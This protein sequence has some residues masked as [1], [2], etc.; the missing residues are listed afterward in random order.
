MTKYALVLISILGG[1]AVLGLIIAVNREDS[2]LSSASTVE[3][4]GETPNGRETG[5]SDKSPLPPPRQAAAPMPLTQAMKSSFALSIG[6]FTASIDNADARLYDSLARLTFDSLT[7][8]ERLSKEEIEWGVT[9]TEF[10]GVEKTVDPDEWRSVMSDLRNRGFRLKSID[11]DR[12]N[13]VLVFQQGHT[14]MARMPIAIHGSHLSGDSWSLSGTVQIEWK[15]VDEGRSASITSIDARNLRFERRARFRGA[16][17]PEPPLPDHLKAEVNEK[18]AKLH[19]DQIEMDKTVWAQEVEAQRYEDT[20][21]K[22]WDRMLRPSDDKYAVLASIPF[23]WI[24]FGSPVDSVLLDWGI[25]RTIFGG[26]VTRRDRAAWKTFLNEM[27]NKSY[28]I[29]NIEFH[30]SS[31]EKDDAG[32]ARS[33]YSTELHVANQDRS[34][35]W[36]VTANLNIEWSDQTDEAD[37]YLIR[38]IKVVDLEVLE[39]EGPPDT[40]K[41]RVRYEG[42]LPV[43]FP[44]LYD[45]DRDGRSEVLLP[46]NNVVL[47]N[48]FTEQAQETRLFDAP[49]ANP[50]VDIKAAVIADFTKDGYADILCAGYDESADHLRTDENYYALLLFRG[51]KDGRFTQP[52]QPVHDVPLRI[53]DPYCMTA[54]DVDGDGD[55]DVWVGQYMAPYLRGQLPTPFHDANDGNPSYLLLNESNGRFVDVTESAGL[56]VKRHRRNYSGSLVDL[57]GDNDLDLLTV[58]D[59]AGIDVYHNDGNGHFSD[60]TN[61]VVDDASNF[62]MA[63]SVADYTLDGK[64][65]FYVIGMSSTTVRRLDQMGIA[66]GDFP[67]YTEM[68]TRMGYGNRMYLGESGGNFKEPSFRDRVARSG[69]AW[70]VTSFDFDSDG[71]LDIYIANGHISRETT[72]DYCSRFWC[73]DVYTNASQEDFARAGFFLDTMFASVNVMSWDGYQKNHLFMNQAGKDFTNVGFLLDVAF[74][75][76]SRSVASDDF[77]LD[78]RPDLLFTNVVQGKR[79]RLLRVLR[80]NWPVANNWIG[81]RLQ[82]EPGA[83][84]PIGAQIEIK[85]PSGKQVARIVTGDSFR[86]QHAPMKHFGLGGAETV[87][88]VRVTWPD[89]R[90]HTERSPAIN[91]YHLVRAPTS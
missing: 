29:I 4:S 7:I 21:V 73:H 3:L 22:Y 54:G 91:T 11:F 71:D 42:R 89:G 46:S 1:L 79:S 55:L 50:P 84:S 63:H 24:S 65:D 16:S 5:S 43:T 80:N 76:D 69:W 70:G 66:R 67:E 68:R 23:D 58:N 8:G 45:L 12:K 9:A 37:R 49:G 31:F 6:K 25:K 75:E 83:P 26:T 35:R 82:E 85:Y 53:K 81:V 2:T 74:V 61:T 28:D 39:R 59:F 47:H 13:S 87:E 41:Q 60:V 48:V 90:V 33:I 52:G 88:F 34:H 56:G 78:G 19:S 32:R 15:T 18:I 38:S 20:I 72:K 77:D 51:D 36:I 64:L 14:A 40:F 30:Q 27:Q 62:G 44:M 86:T 57:D 17:P 10:A